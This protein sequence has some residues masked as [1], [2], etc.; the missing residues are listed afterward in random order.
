MNT[1]KKYSLAIL[2]AS[3]I[4]PSQYVVKAMDPEFEDEEVV[5][6]LPEVKAPTQ[7]AVDAYGRDIYLRMNKLVNGLR[8]SD[9]TA[10][11]R[12]TAAEDL[13]K[14]FSADVLAEGSLLQLYK[15][16]LDACTLKYDEN[17]SLD[18][19]DNSYRKKLFSALINNIFGT[20]SN[21]GLFRWATTPILNILGQDLVI[22]VDGEDLI[23]QFLLAI[24]ALEP[25]L[26]MQQPGILEEKTKI[27]HWMEQIN[28]LWVIEDIPEGDFDD[29]ADTASANGDE[30]QGAHSSNHRSRRQNYDRTN[31]PEG[32]LSID[33]DGRTIVY[34]K[35]DSQTVIIPEDGA[36]WV[37]A[38]PDDF[39]K[40]PLQQNNGLTYEAH[41]D[42]NGKGTTAAKGVVSSVVSRVQGLSGV[43]TGG[44]YLL[45]DSLVSG[46]LHPEMVVMALMVGGATQTLQYFFS[47]AK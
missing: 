32:I 46:E 17:L 16:E 28:S 3:A 31:D 19:Q 21:P 37:V 43:V 26:L 7:E 1:I 11:F 6:Q 22:K 33:F 29:E 35:K 4:L 12:A 24:A 9:R 20:V 42:S 39:S 36:T 14:L 34:L 8:E 30:Y 44:G 47:R 5:E 10:R 27:A 40:N 38:D 25:R 2:L 23:S 41:T 15:Q 18:W 45:L 13:A